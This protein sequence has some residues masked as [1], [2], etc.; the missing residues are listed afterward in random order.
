MKCVPMGRN[1]T[2]AVVTDG[3]KKAVKRKKHRTLP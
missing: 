2:S 1:N 3:K